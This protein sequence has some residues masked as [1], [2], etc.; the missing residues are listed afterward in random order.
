MKRWLPVGVLAGALF[1]INVVARLVVRFKYNT[2][3]APVGRISLIMLVAVG[4]ACLVAAVLWGRNQPL[5]RWSADLTAAAV[6][7]LALAVFV[8][9]FLNSNT[10]FGNGA[11]EFFK[12]I[13]QW[14]AFSG[15][16]AAL[17]FGI[18]TALGIDYRSKSL[19]RYAE[20]KLAKPRRP[21][22]R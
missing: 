22:R 14:A 11:G 4:L 2:E 9:P 6:V 7:G 15:V 19:K 8:G 21:V 18:I 13:W 5:G 10:P 1:A 12:Q 16:G 20:A 3:D 17:G